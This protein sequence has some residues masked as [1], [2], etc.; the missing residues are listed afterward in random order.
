MPLPHDLIP[1]RVEHTRGLQSAH[2][3][4]PAALEK[5]RSLG[6]I[7]RRVTAGSSGDPAIPSGISGYRQRAFRRQREKVSPGRFEMGMR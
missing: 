1:D 3:A 7:A 5:R 6:L 4:P 2:T